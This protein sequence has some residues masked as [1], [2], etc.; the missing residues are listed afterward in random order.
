MLKN[1]KIKAEDLLI[2][3]NCS[4][5]SLAEKE[6]IAENGEKE[7]IRYA[8][9][10]YFFLTH[11][12]PETFHESEKYR[13][14]AQIKHSVHRLNLTRKIKQWSAVAA[15]VSVCIIGIG[16][17]HQICSIPKIVDY[18]HNIE[19]IDTVKN[20]LLLLQ[21]NHHVTIL[22]KESEI[23]YNRNGKDI[24]INSDHTVKQEFDSRKT[25]YNTIILPY[26]KRTQITLSE[27]TKVWLNSGSK[28]V[29]PA[30]FNQDKREVYIEGEAVFEVTPDKHIP[31]YVNTNDFTIQ[32]LGTVFCV[33]SYPEDE[34]SSAVLERGHIEISC[35][36]NLLFEEKLAMDPGTRVIFNPEEKVFHQK[37]V[38]P[39]D[40]LSWR[41]GY[42]TFHSE[43]LKSII[44]KLSRY[45][46][47]E[48]IINDAQLAD[49]TFSGSMDLKN[50]PEEVL[51]VIAETTPFLLQHED[52][53]LIIKSR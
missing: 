23:C 40:Y 37:Q 45:Y 13:L 48:I 36:K 28:L 17:Y 47:E 43:K 49:E 53:K 19:I 27:G 30:V 3:E 46:N 39:E 22:K 26:G 4:G 34:Y 16:R 33:S 12:H 8:R 7:E 20:T 9:Q 1:S 25:I 38:D 6:I 10:I 42:Y 52:R 14:K 18:A 31:F 11:F 21:N 44:K 50:S 24:H 29:Y 2:E 15:V 32:V 5:Q 51:E 41:K 35:K